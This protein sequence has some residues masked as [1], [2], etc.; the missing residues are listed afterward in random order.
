MQLFYQRLPLLHSGTLAVA[1]VPFDAHASYQRGAAEAPD[2]IREAFHSRS[3]N[4]YSEDGTEINGHPGI[5]DLG[6]VPFKDYQ[7]ISR[8][9]EQV[10][11]AGARVLS[12]GGD[13]SITFPIIRAFSKHYPNLTI[14]QFDAHGDLY[15]ELDGNR[16]SHACPFARIMEEQLAARLVQVGV[17]SLTDHQRAQIDRFGVEVHECRDGLPTDL[18]LQGPLYISLDLDVLDPAFAPGV[19]HYEPGGLSV[20]EVLDLLHRIDAPIVGADIV[21]YNPRKDIH[22]MTAMVA[23]KYFRELAAAMLKE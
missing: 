14:L 12:F 10:L 3:A 17:R 13:H 23:A 15:D 9:Y 20:R 11:D 7:D 5:V 16:F 2:R 21:E 8:H 6:A 4:T 22:N 19:S 1:G 18:D